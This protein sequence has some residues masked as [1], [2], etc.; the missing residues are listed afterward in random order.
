MPVRMS[1]EVFTSIVVDVGNF[2]VSI[3]N[4]V[5]H[6]INSVTNATILDAIRAINVAINI[7]NDV[8][9]PL[10]LPFMIFMLDNDEEKYSNPTYATP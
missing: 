10:F 1:F 9:A 2:T 6:V 3:I 4:I 7:F 5:N 8:M